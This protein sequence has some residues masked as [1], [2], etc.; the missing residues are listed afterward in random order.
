[1]MSSLVLLTQIDMFIYDKQFV[2][3]S[4]RYVGLFDDKFDF[5]TSINYVSS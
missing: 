3:F 1:M 5:D 4:I 2:S